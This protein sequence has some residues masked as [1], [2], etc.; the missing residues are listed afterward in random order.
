LP[1]S[2]DIKKTNQQI[3]SPQIYVVCQ[4]KLFSITNIRTDDNQKLV[5]HCE[6]CPT[7]ADLRNQ[8]NFGNS[9]SQTMLLFVLTYSLLL[10]E[11]DG[12]HCVLDESFNCLG[13]IICKLSGRFFDFF[14]RNLLIV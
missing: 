2:T 1:F 12:W 4:K 6:D 3:P 8:V 11:S 5:K 13:V 7:F 9:A 14:P 10:R